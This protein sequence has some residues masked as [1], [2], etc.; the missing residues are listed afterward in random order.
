MVVTEIEHAISEDRKSLVLTE[1]TSPL[2]NIL[3]GL[4]GPVSS[5]LILHGPMSKK[6]SANNNMRDAVGLTLRALRHSVNSSD[7][8]ALRNAEQLLQ[9]QKPCVRN[10]SYVMLNERSSLVTGETAAAMRR[11]WCAAAVLN[12]IVRSRPPILCA[13]N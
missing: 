5:P 8:K 1:R 4:D 11:R 6:R 9:A 2:E 10:Y 13:W 12:S 7:P 3:A